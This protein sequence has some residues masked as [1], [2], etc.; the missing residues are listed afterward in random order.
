MI[1]K[2]VTKFGKL[3]IYVQGQFNNLSSAK[4]TSLKLYTIQLCI[5]IFSSYS[6]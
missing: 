3:L 6:K 1:Y 2:T 4:A 5:E